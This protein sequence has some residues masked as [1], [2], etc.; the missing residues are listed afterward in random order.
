ML[1][2]SLI[3]THLA[4]PQ[5]VHLENLYYV[6]G[7]LKENPKMRLAFNPA[8]PEISKKRFQQYDWQE[9]YCDATE[10][11]TGDMPM[12]RGKSM[13]KNCFVDADLAGNT[14]TRRSQTSILIFFN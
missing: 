6:F 12:P 10:A 5:I 7:F 2:V 4:L 3:S 13:P 11:V 9:F 1:K 14:V 8:H